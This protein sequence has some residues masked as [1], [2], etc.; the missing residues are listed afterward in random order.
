MYLFQFQPSSFLNE[1]HKIIN[2]PMMSID[3]IYNHK[4]FT[5]H[6]KDN[7][8]QVPVFFFLLDNFLSHIG[9]V[10]N[11]II[12]ES[13]EA[14]YKKMNVPHGHGD[15]IKWEHFLL[16]WPLMTGGFPHKVQWHDALMFSLIWACT[17]GWANSRDAG[18]L[19]RHRAHHGVTLMQCFRWKFLRYIIKHAD[20]TNRNLDLIKR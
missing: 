10:S 8:I 5:I 14:L 16:Y 13:T 11:E 7:K 18:D 6:L 2:V 20:T 9:V 15:V 17:N 3:Y 19:R 12:F 1:I 4:C